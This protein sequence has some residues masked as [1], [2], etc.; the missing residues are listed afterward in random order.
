MFS[1]LRQACGVESA[2]RIN[3]TNK[4]FLVYAAL[5]GFVNKTKQPLLD[6]ILSYDN[7]LL[8]TI[9]PVT[10]AAETPLEIWMKSSPIFKSEHINAH[11]NDYMRA[12]R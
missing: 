6:A 1:S 11:M 5:V 8:T 7:V 2:A 4:I 3:P 9:D 10:Y 12:V